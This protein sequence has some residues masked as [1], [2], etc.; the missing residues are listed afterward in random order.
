MCDGK[1]VGTIPKGNTYPG[2]WACGF[3]LGPTGSAHTAIVN[4]AVLPISANRNESVELLSQSLDQPHEKP[5]NM[6][7]QKLVRK[8][9]GAEQLRQAVAA[10]LN[11]QDLSSITLRDLRQG[12]EQR[13]CLFAGACDARCDE[14]RAY[15][16]E[17]V[18]QEA[19]AL[20][21]SPSS[22][23]SALAML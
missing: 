23:A 21:A 13:L 7:T 9:V 18:R 22:S 15:A 12:L 10:H 11:G 8:S 14:V 3:V 1:T 20:A 6:I 4:K 5:A 17:V 16:A 2:P 19:A